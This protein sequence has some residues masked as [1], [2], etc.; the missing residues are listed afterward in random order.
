MMKEKIKK[1]KGSLISR[2]LK[3]K[4]P[5][6]GEGEVYEKKKKFFQLPV[7][8]EECN[9]CHYHFD[10]EP[11]YFLGAMYIS[12]GLAVFQGIVTFILLYMVFPDLPTIAV[13]LIILAVI[14]LFSLKNY[15]LSRIIYMH[16]F[17]E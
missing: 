8:K 2:I 15:K 14:C 3:E 16:I 10:R 7:M 9:N 13:V 4:C 17:P 1:V 11:G 12:Y 5:N 6:C